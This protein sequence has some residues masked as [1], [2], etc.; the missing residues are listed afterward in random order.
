MGKPIL[1]FATPILLPG[2]QDAATTDIY[3][4]DGPILYAAGRV[5]IESVPR[6][7][8][9]KKE[10]IPVAEMEFAVTG[11]SGEGNSS[12]GPGDL[13][14]TGSL[15]RQGPASLSVDYSLVETT[16]CFRAGQRWPEWELVALVG[17]GAIY[18]ELEVSDGTRRGRRVDYR[19][20]L[21]LGAQ[22]SWE[23]LPR[24]D[25]FARGTVLYSW[26]SRSLR[27]E[28]GPGYRFTDWLRGFL[29]YRWWQ[30]RFKPENLVTDDRTNHF[31]VTTHGVVLGV[32]LRF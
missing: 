6:A 8:V 26:D 22:G 3:T 13:V 19:P 7:P 30:Y 20:G 4:T 11:A 1:L 16:A 27:L 24:F 5:V 32:E 14:R 10:G 9:E 23:P 29:A 25:V 28:L 17:L 2:F 21:V 31:E 15:T 18:N 12:I